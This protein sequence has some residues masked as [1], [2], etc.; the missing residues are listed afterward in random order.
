MSPRPNP[1]MPTGDRGLIAVDKVGNA[2]LFLDPVTLATQHTLTG[3]SPSVHELTVSPDHTTAFVP[4]YGDGRHGANP[5]PGHELVVIDLVGRYQTATFDLG[6]YR[7]PHSLRWG[8]QGELYC[9][10]EDSGVVLELDAETGRTRDVIEVGSTNAHRM[11]IL[12]NGSKLYT[13][14]EEDL[15][16]T[17]VDLRRRSRLADVPAP[18]GLTGIGMSPDGAT[19]VLVDAGRPELH[20]VDPATDTVVRSVRLTGHEQPAQI[21]RYSPDGRFAVV[22]SIDEGLATILDAGLDRVGTVRTGHQPMDMAFHPDG[23]VVVIGNQGDGTLTVVDLLEAR[24]L[25]SVEAGSGVECL[26]YY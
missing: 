22:T 11:E 7:A 13:E 20:V 15:F 26:S 10:C 14:N 2:V 4:I 3:F 21:A 25:R 18:H 24:L 5:H 12:P 8:P 1:N 17:V 6:P 19:I 16:V 9:L 23:G